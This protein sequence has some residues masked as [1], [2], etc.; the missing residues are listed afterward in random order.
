MGPAETAS[1]SGRSSGSML[2]KIP[3]GAMQRSLSGSSV[4][5]GRQR[6][7]VGR[8]NRSSFESQQSSVREEVEKQQEKER[9]EQEKERAASSRSYGSM[10]SHSRSPSVSV[11]SAGS[12]RSRTSHLSRTSSTSLAHKEA[13]GYRKMT[14]L[15]VENPKYFVE[16]EM[17]REAV[18]LPDR[19][20]PRWTRDA[21]KTQPVGRYSN[22]PKNKDTDHI[23]DDR[24]PAYERAMTAERFSFV[25]NTRQG[26]N[27]AVSVDDRAKMDRTLNARLDRRRRNEDRV[28]KSAAAEIETKRQLEER[29]IRGITRQQLSYLEAV[30]NREFN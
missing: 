13:T 12:H 10:R 27:C 18:F 1:H 8:T 11:K 5:S 9:K 24:G 30:A 7:V 2:P 28:L 25:E 19:K 6:A 4:G 15:A 17:K 16:R 14:G 29:H 23:R 22:R 3:V 20:P 26:H 21:L